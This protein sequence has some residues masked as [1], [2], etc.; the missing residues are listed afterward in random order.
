MGIFIDAF[1]FSVFIIFILGVCFV[2]SLTLIVW[3]ELAKQ[4]YNMKKE[5]KHKKQIKEGDN[6]GNA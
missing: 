6:K 3:W 4:K 1:C 5:A 2:T